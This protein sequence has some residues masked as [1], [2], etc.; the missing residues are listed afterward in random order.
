MSPFKKKS[1]ALL[2]AGLL[3]S[4]LAGC[5]TV[6]YPE[7][8]GQQGGSID[9][10]VAIANGV[11]LLFFIIPG[12]VAF[13]VDF[14]NGSIYLPG[15]GRAELAPEVTPDSLNEQLYV[16]TGKRINWQQDTV[17]VEQLSSTALAQLRLQQ[18][19]NQG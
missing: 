3:T 15:G 9:P 19:D 4:Q 7:R 8:K 14:N 2:L 1:L 16:S 17:Q 12:V 5:G 11:G 13:A 18:Q 10:V 6:F